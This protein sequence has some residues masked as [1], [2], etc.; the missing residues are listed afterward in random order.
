MTQ[1][2]RQPGPNP[3]RVLQSTRMDA[4]RRVVLSTLYASAVAFMLAGVWLLVA[5]QSFFDAEIA[6][7]VGMAFV[8]T[9]L[10]DVVA[11]AVLKRLWSGK[12]ARAR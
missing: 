11:V 2:F 3:S 8:I 4:S 7:W 12:P 5:D 10:S 6:P 1:D 9:A